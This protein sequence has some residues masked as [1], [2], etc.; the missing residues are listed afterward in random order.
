M[1]DLYAPLWNFAHLHNIHHISSTQVEIQEHWITNPGFMRLLLQTWNKCS[2]RKEL[3]WQSAHLRPLPWVF[4][5][6][7]SFGKFRILI[8]KEPPIGRI[9]R[10]CKQT[11]ISNAYRHPVLVYKGITRLL[12]HEKPGDC[13]Q[14][15][16]LGS[17]GNN[18]GMETTW[19]KVETETC[20]E[21]VRM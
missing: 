13:R 21:V 8:I 7:Y 17:Y 12:L 19:D 3:S 10:L 1:R 6:A 15:H 20:C 5:D 11:R 14:G 4:I 16:Y 18:W 9:G 2:H